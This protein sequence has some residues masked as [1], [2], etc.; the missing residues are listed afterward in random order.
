MYARVDR[1]KEFA[2]SLAA[3]AAYV[4]W[5]DRLRAAG[6]P[7]RGARS[8]ASGLIIPA[9][10]AA[11][12]LMRELLALHR[13]GDAVL[14]EQ[15]PTPGRITWVLDPLNGTTN[16]LY[17]LP[18]YA[19]SIAAQLDDVVLAGAVAEPH[20]QRIWS[21]GLGQGARLHDR[22][23][24]RDWLEI[25]V[26]ST[27]HLDD[28][29]ISTGFSPVAATSADQ[30]DLVARLRPHVADLRITGSPALQ[31][32]HV[33]AGWS[34]AY[35]QHDVG[36]R[37]RVAGLLIADEAGAFVHS[38]GRTGPGSQLGDP[39]IAAAPRI[40]DALLEVLAQSGAA[41]VRRA[42]HDQQLPAVL[43]GRTA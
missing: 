30:A 21:A 15:P 37:E 1:L 29:L 13:P 33:A 36:L 11:E 9:A 34:D 23:I 42:A 17:G 22:N 14:S 7:L 43:P 18:S 20:S 2:E 24:S 10:L 32:C 19:V 6:G 12:R 41:A 27:Q 31:L 28:A 5:T 3:R 8:T 35:V 26:G 4:I 16:Y 25:R 40:S 39:V 38:P